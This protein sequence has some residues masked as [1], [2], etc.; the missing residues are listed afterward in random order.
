MWGPSPDSMSFFKYL[1]QFIKR[2]ISWSRNIHF[3]IFICLRCFYSH[4][5][6]VITMYRL[7]SVVAITGYRKNPEVP[8]EII[9]IVYENFFGPEYQSWPEYGIAQ[10]RI[11][12]HPFHGMLFCEIRKVLRPVGIGHAYM[13]KLPCPCPFSSLKQCSSIG[14]RLF[15]A[16]ISPVKSCPMG[17]VNS[18]YTHHGIGKL[19]KLV[20]TREDRYYFIQH[21]TSFRVP[22]YC[23]NPASCI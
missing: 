22:C 7:Q 2:I 18:V 1:N 19:I 8:Q 5:G 10:S 23:P 13:D 11:L 15:K 14:Q 12:P 3:Q 21:I 6:K 16:R 17:I 20:K 9:N 4:P